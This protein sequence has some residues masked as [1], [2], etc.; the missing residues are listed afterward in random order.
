MH[1]DHVF[2]IRSAYSK[3]P[4]AVFIIPSQLS[5][6]SNVERPPYQNVDPPH[7]VIAPGCLADTPPQI[8][9]KQ[10]MR[11]IKCYL[12]RAVKSTSYFFMTDFNVPSTFHV[13]H[14]SA[15]AAKNLWTPPLE[16]QKFSI[17]SLSQFKF[18][19]QPHA[20][21]RAVAAISI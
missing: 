4:T 18:A 15:A 3:L 7:D 12:L 13:R 20:I 5:K 6:V 8:T 2:D 14:I 16:L 10:K 9:L 11:R 17:V 19:P 21:H 1:G